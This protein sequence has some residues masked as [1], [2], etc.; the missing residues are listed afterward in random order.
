M[1]NKNIKSEEFEDNSNVEKDKETKQKSNE[2]KGI[3][4]FAKESD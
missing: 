2:D 3:Y 1:K 4:G